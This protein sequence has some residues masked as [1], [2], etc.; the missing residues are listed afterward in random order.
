MTAFTTMRERETRIFGTDAELSGDGSSVTVRDFASGETVRH[1]VEEEVTSRHGGGDDGI[2]DDFV[3]A[4]TAGDPALVPTT[5][6]LTLESHRIAFA[7]EASRR[8]GRVVELNAM[9]A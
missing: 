7:A 5:P 4:A 1:E 3:A 2:M 6:A 8:E 9:P